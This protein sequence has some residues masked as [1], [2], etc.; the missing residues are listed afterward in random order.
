M[1]ISLCDSPT[2][3]LW[4]LTTPYP[5]Q[6]YRHVR[7]I[8]WLT[9]SVRVI[10]RNRYF[11]C[12]HINSRIIN[13]SKL[14]L[15]IYNFHIY[16]HAIAYYR[17]V[18]F[19]LFISCFL[20]LSAIKLVKEKLQTS[21]KIKLPITCYVLSEEITLRACSHLFVFSFLSCIS[22]MYKIYI[23]QQIRIFT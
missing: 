7:V 22:Y 2:S 18:I 16:F 13:V 14:S 8:S 23:R 4:R 11:L 9:L 20:Q 17:S 5:D 12:C 21:W 6:P 3:L 1:Q 15:R 10:K 19:R